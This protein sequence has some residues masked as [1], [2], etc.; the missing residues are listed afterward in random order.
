MLVKLA[1]PAT[2]RLPGM[3]TATVEEPRVIRV[4]VSVMFELFRPVP[5]HLGKVF[6]VSCAEP[7]IE[8]VAGEEPLK[9]DPD[10]PRPGKREL[11]RVPPLAAKAAVTAKEADF[12]RLPV[13]KTEPV[14]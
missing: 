5:V 13:S 3:L 10:R 1:V 4:P 2:L 12:A 6:V 8:N 7:D 9:V 14:T 11:T